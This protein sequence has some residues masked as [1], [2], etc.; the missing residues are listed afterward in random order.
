VAQDVRSRRSLT[1]ALPPTLLLALLPPACG[2]DDDAPPAPRAVDLAAI[3]GEQLAEAVLRECHAPLR[4]AMAR[5]AATVTLPDGR[6]VTAFVELPDRLRAQS[7][8]ARRRR[9]PRR[10]RRATK[11]G[12][13]A[14]C[15]TRRRSGRCT[16]PGAANASTRPRSRWSRPTAR[17]RA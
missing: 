7:T 8:A 12:G 10:R 3:P 15:S 17:R 6:V 16:A 5:L 11:R 9:R 4:S 14:R 2:R 13:C 1:S